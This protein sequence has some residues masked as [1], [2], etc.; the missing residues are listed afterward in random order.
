MRTENDNTIKSTDRTEHIQAGI[1][2]LIIACA[3]VAVP[4]ILAIKHVLD[5]SSANVLFGMTVWYIFA[6][7]AAVFGFRFVRLGAAF[8]ASDQKQ[9]V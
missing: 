6:V 9:T 5:L 1:I 8:A 2:M 7:I 3:M 4:S